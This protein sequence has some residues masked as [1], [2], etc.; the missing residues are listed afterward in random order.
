MLQDNFITAYLISLLK[1]LPN[2]MK[3]KLKIYQKN[4]SSK[5]GEIIFYPNNKE[6]LDY[7][8]QSYVSSQK[9]ELHLDYKSIYSYENGLKETSSFIDWYYER[10][11]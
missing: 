9:A 8:N 3:S 10:S 7:K 11:N 5:L 1:K 4:L 6:I 2:S